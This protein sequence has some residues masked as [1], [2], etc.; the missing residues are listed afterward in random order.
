[1]GLV[2]VPINAILDWGMGTAA[3]FA[4]YQD[5][6]VNQMLKRLLDRLDTVLREPSRL[7]AAQNLGAFWTRQVSAP[8]I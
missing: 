5:P 1:V 7:I 3:G 8:D 6:Q 2:G 4:V